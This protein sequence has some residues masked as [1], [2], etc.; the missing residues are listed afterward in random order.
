MFFLQRHLLGKLLVVCQRSHSIAAIFNEIELHAS[1]NCFPRVHIFDH[2]VL[3]KAIKRLQSGLTYFILTFTE[4]TKCNLLFFTDFYVVCLETVELKVQDI[5]NL[6]EDI[7]QW[8][9]RLV[10]V[11]SLCALTK[12]IKIVLLIVS[13]LRDVANAASDVS[14]IERFR[15]LI[16]KFFLEDACDVCQ[17]AVLILLAGAHQRFLNILSR[18]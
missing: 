8:E 3:D 1:R 2:L 6:N 15:V 12:C 7:A 9:D 11:K 4:G 16:A 14:L 17:V 18:Y 13:H 10:K 5:S